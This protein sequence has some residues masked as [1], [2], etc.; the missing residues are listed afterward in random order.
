MRK[1]FLTIMLVGSFVSLCSCSDPA[2]GGDYGEA[3]I[4]MPQATKNL[5][6][7]NNLN[8]SIDAAMVAV[9]PENR[10]QTTLGIYRSGTEEK[11]TATVDLVINTDSL[12]T[13]QA[14]AAAP[15]ADGKYDIYKT[16]VLLEE[17]YYEPLP[18]KLTINGGERQATTQLILHD[19]EIVADYG[20]GSILLLPVQIKNP[21]RYSLNESLS[22]TMVVIRI[23]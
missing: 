23:K 14:I 10:T 11:L 4:Y 13:A 15:G 17:K 18:K 16:G 21:T 12:A 19:S 3:L 2:V 9:D 1:V 8:L 5:G 20:A 7:D 22:L 6:I